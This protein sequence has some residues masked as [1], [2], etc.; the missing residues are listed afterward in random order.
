MVDQWARLQDLLDSAERDVVARHALDTPDTLAFDAAEADQLWAQIKPVLARMSPDQAQ[1]LVAWSGHD[2]PPAQFADRFAEH[3]AQLR[4]L[5]TAE[6]Y[7]AAR[8]STTNT[9][10]T[11]AMLAAS[12]WDGLH[13]LGFRAGE[14]LEP[15]CGAGHFLGLAPDEASLTG[16]EREP[17]SAAIAAALYP[18]HRVLTGSF[19]DIEAAEGSFDVAVGNVP[20]AKVVLNDAKHNPGRHSLHNHFIIKSLRLTRPGGMV[21][22]LTS[23]YTMDARN[24]AARREMA[25]LA[26]LVGAIRLPTG[27]HRR[28][29][30]TEAVTDLLILRRRPEGAAPDDTVVAPESWDRAAPIVLGTADTG[31]EGMVEINQYFCDHPENVLG[32]YHLGQGMHGAQTLEVR[33][34]LDNLGVEFAAAVHRIADDAVARDMVMTERTATTPRPAATVHVVDP[35]AARFQGFLT[36]HEDGTFTRRNGH[37]DASYTPA[38]KQ[39]DELRALL[40]VRDVTMALIKAEQACVDDTDE[41]RH[42][43]ADLNRVYDAYVHEYGPIN[44]FAERSQKRQAWHLFGEWCA[45][46]DFDKTPASPAM[47]RAYFT[48]LATKGLGQDQLHRHLNGI[49][50]AHATAY[51]SAAAKAVKKITA[52]TA[53]LRDLDRQETAEL[54]VRLQGKDPVWLLQQAKMPDPRLPMASIAAALGAISAAPPTTDPAFDYAEVGLEQTVIIR[55]DQGGFRHDPFS[56]IARALE[57][58]DPTTQTARKADIFTQRV[59]NPPRTRRGTDS[60]E[61]ALSICLD[62][63]SRIDLGEIAWL[64]GLPGEQE[65]RAA[66]DGHVFDDPETGEVVWAPFYLAGNVRHKLATA[67]LAAELDPKYEANVAALEPVIPEDKGPDEIEVRLGSWIGPEFVEQFLHELL[68]G[69]KYRTQPGVARPDP[70]VQVESVAGIWL[71]SADASKQTEAIDLNATQ[72]WAGGGLDAFELTERLLIGSPIEVFKKVEYVD[73]HG[74]IKEKAVLDPEATAEAADMAA[75]ISDRFADWVWEDTNRAQEVMRRYNDAFNAEIPVDYTRIELSLPGLSATFSVDGAK[76]LRDHQKIAIARIIYQGGT[77]LVHD[78][79]AGKTLEMIIGVMER[80]RRG[81]ADKPVIV[82]PNDS[83]AQQ[84]ER[85]WLQAY[86]GARLLT[87]TS[88]ELAENQKGRHRRAEFVARVATGDW[89]AVIMTKE[90]FQ[91]IPLPAEIQKGFLQAELDDLRAE[92]EAHADSMSQSMTKRIESAMEKATERL[93]RRLAA[94]ERDVEGVSFTEAGFDFIVVDEAQNYK[95]GLVPSA[96]E[97]LVIPGSNRA[98]DL[99]MKLGYLHDTHGTARAVLA[100]ATPWTGKYSEIYLWQRRLGHRMPRFDEWARTY[101]TVAQYMEMAPGNKLR[102]KTRTRRPINEPELWWSLRLT[103]DVKMQA[104][105]GLKL[106]ALRDG[107]IEIIEVSA[108]EQASI[109]TLDLARRERQLTGKPEKGSDNFLWISHD[110]QLAATDLRTVG[111]T[112]DQPQKVDEVADDIYR[113]YLLAKD[114]VYYRDDGTEHPVRGGCLLVFCDESTPSP[115]WNFYT[116]LRER[117]VARGMNEALIRFIHEGRSPQRLADL[118]SGAREGGVAVLLGSTM[119]M[120]AGLN[121]QDRLIGGYEITGQWRPDIPAQAIGRVKRQGNQNGEYFWKRVVLAPSMDA[122]KWEI[123]AQKQAMFSALYAPEPPGRSR[124]LPND[125]GQSLADVMAAATGDP[126]Y[127]EK[128]ELDAELK[129]L[130]RQQS[131]HGRSQQA[132][133]LSRTHSLQCIPRL[134]AQAERQDAAASQLVSIDGDTFTMDVGSRTFTKRSEAAEALREQFHTLLVTA[135]RTKEGLTNQIGVIGGLTVDATCYPLRDPRDRFT[136]SFPDA[137]ENTAGFVLADALPGGTGLVIRLQNQLK[138][139]A[140]AGDRTRAQIHEEH[141]KIATAEAAIGTPFTGVQRLAEVVARRNELIEQLSPEDETWDPN[142]DSNSPEAIARR[143]REEAR[144]REFEALTEEAV[145]LARRGGCTSPA[146]NRFAGWYTEIVRPVSAEQRPSMHAALD[147]WREVG[148]PDWK[149][150]SQLAP[151][152]TAR[153][154]V[155]LADDEDTPRE[156]QPPPKDATPTL[157]GGEQAGQTVLDA[158]AGTD[159]DEQWSALRRELADAGWQHQR[160]DHAGLGGVDPHRQWCSPTPATTSQTNCRL[161]PHTWKTRARRPTPP[162]PPTSSTPPQLR[163][164]PRPGRPSRP[165]PAS[166]PSRPARPGRPA[167]RWIGYRKPAHGAGSLK[168]PPV[169]THT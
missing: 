138:L 23:R 15:G 115:H 36:A 90:S 47:L 55:P 69:E 137:R 168:P 159:L 4:R 118:L 119:K 77:G 97:D 16:V 60:A 104:E 151:L 129:T 148:T 95:N 7:A 1:A 158:L 75:Q 153:R 5:L 146:A 63:H 29:A 85:E 101:V 83:I 139:I 86:P 149:G 9:H 102:T 70:F 144:R 106:P 112:T 41:I 88:D 127:K 62:K 142:E 44:R 143:E 165:G 51:K 150:R 42:L 33:G 38:T 84:F 163:Q 164:R 109:F 37:E 167:G 89:D 166:R 147:V 152:G 57:K 133:K 25:E 161:S 120:G 34:K 22:V 113:E 132:L 67:R 76:P 19:T 140:D 78:V 94:I 12:M 11:D 40:G 93:E 27:A 125:E 105:L 92:K 79:G 91:S 26:D 155:Q 49:V 39:A 72:I 18:Q 130:T 108:S 54:E 45:G 107:N 123:T 52:D 13:R 58:F 32:D 131:S 134:Q 80:H 59:I 136:V 157:G 81:L 116:E 71:V 53:R 154:A 110:G 3:R 10:Y 21:A 20:F 30:G 56:N 100:T 169:P 128:A 50:K 64:L 66:L 8:R 43:R 98:I 48:D 87:G 117:L 160:R 126:R 35:E 114:N 111:I 61:E 122:K 156:L 82:V 99:D 121:I 74:E 162:L 135:P 141:E 24:P 31:A 65:A 14:V 6:Q 96:I 17:I 28:A 68:G 103:S 2:A 124:E 145:D 46:H 73:S